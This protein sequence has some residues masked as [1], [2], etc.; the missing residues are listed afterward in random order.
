VSVNLSVRQV[1]LT[2]LVAEVQ[3]ALERTGLAASLLTVELTETVLVEAG[4]AR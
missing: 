4:H 2:D 3:E 1:D